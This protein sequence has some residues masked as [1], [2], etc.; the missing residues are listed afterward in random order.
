MCFV[1][2]VLLL[3]DLF[4]FNYFYYQDG[5][6]CIRA[7]NYVHSEGF[8]AWDQKRNF[9][10]RIRSTSN[11]AELFCPKV[12]YTR[13]V[14]AVWLKPVLKWANVCSPNILLLPLK[15]LT[16]EQFRPYG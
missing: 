11:T 14:S 13:A 16:H 10:P 5:S 15:S 9:S 8:L 6:L 2:L 1:A 7:N 4:I 3:L 12:T